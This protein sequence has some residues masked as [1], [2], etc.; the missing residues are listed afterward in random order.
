MFVVSPTVSK[1]SSQLRAEMRQKTS[2]MVGDVSKIGCV[3][4]P[5]KQRRGGC[6][7]KDGRQASDDEETMQ[8]SSAAA[9]TRPPIAWRTRQASGSKGPRGRKPRC[10]AARESARPV[11]I[12]SADAADAEAFPRAGGPTSTRSRVKKES[13][14]VLRYFGCEQPC[15]QVWMRVPAQRSAMGPLGEGGRTMQHTSSTLHEIVERIACPSRAGERG[16][17]ESGEERDADQE[18]GFMLV[19]DK[20]SSRRAPGASGSC[21]S[22]SRRS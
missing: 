14:R 13:S 19:I 5:T 16:R 3:S 22:S 9:G 12:K 18:G 1:L 17:S 2:D 8:A 10:T 7:D 20:S 4:P 6:E 11:K 15:Q 21:A